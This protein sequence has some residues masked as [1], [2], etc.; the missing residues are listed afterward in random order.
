[1]KIL[2]GVTKSIP[3][4]CVLV[5]RENLIE[6][7]EWCNGSVAGLTGVEYCTEG[8][9]HSVIWL[10]VM[11]GEYLLKTEGGFMDYT[12]EEFERLIDASPDE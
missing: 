6:V 11:V 8:L 3:V 4:E 1:M 10:R 12:S 2:S 7:A 9:T 5:E